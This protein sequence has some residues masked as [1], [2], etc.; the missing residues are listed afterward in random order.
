MFSYISIYIFI[1]LPFL[2]LLYS[3][4]PSFFLFL[5]L[6]FSP[7]VSFNCTLPR[8][9]RFST[10]LKSFHPFCTFPWKNYR[11]RET[12]SSPW[13]GR[14]PTIKIFRS[15]RSR[16]RTIVSQK[17]SR[18]TPP[19]L[20]FIYSLATPLVLKHWN[21]SPRCWQKKINI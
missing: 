12:M 17:R 20:V 11:S 7:S 9:G 4:M 6:C 18:P 5:F 2:H 16:E 3:F 15:V 1:C 21:P 10:F 13:A 14:V 8:A 19:H